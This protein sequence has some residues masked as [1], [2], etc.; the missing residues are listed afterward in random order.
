MK[1]NFEYFLNAVHFMIY[2]DRFG[3]VRKSRR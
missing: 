3:Q 1:E 2:N